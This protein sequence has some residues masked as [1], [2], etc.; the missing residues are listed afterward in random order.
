MT[1]FYALILFGLMGLSYGQMTG[2]LPSS[3][4]GVEADWISIGLILI[5]FILLFTIYRY[6]K[7]KDHEY[8]RARQRDEVDSELSNKK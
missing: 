4:T 3:E 5:F 6:S 2:V 8:G 7:N 1:K